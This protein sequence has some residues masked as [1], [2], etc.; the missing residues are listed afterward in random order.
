MNTKT[1]FFLF[2]ILLVC[3]SCGPF[4]DIRELGDID[5][6]PPVINKI[7]SIDCNKIKLELSEASVIGDNYVSVSPGLAVTEIESIE[8]Y[9]II[10]TEI[11]IPGAKYTM[12][13]EIKD[14]YDNSVQILAA[15]YGY[16]HEIP[17]IKI[18]EFTTRGSSSHPDMVELKVFTDGNMG[19]ITA[20]QG[21]PG[22]Y[23][24]M[25]VFPAFNVEKDDF[26]ILHFKPENSEE[27]INETEEK[28]ISGGLDASDEAFDL[29]IKD[30][31]GISG[32]NGV[33]S[34]YERPGGPLID[35]VLY[36]NRTSDSDESYLGF[37]TRSTME[38]ALEICRDNGWITG[39]ETV[40]PEDAVNPEGST[41]TRSICRNNNDTDS[42]AD[43]YIV[44][45]RGYTFGTENSEEV[46]KP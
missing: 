19:G 15:F 35:S 44:P 4:P 24:D 32:N 31:A 36:S 7:T 39:N 9:I 10:T 46:Y 1:I 45:T 14:Q 13:A 30:G 5:L 2:L 18:N 21:T 40:C 33:I 17:C 41:S 37:G 6:K 43:W 38:R 22:D 23:K 27:E 28:N 16:N 12:N 25:Y 29:W 26:I 34:I 8:N 20:Y 42:K 3:N 11:Q